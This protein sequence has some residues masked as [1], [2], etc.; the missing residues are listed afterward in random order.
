LTR[1]CRGCAHIAAMEFI[2][3][4][5]MMPDLAGVDSL[6]LSPDSK[7]LAVGRSDGVLEI[8]TTST[9]QRRIAFGGRQGRVPKCLAFAA[10][11]ECNVKKL[12]WAE[13]AKYQLIS[14]GL[15]GKLHL[16]DLQSLQPVVTETSGGGA[17]YDMCVLDTKP[18]TTLAL[19]CE[20]GA[21]HLMHVDEES[22]THRRKFHGG[23][24][25]ML[26]VCRHR[27]YVFGGNSTSLISRWS[28]D[29]RVSDS[30]VRLEKSRWGDE[31]LVWA[32][33]HVDE[34]S[35]VS[36]DSLGLLHIIDTV[37]C[38]V[39]QRLDQHQADVLTLAVGTGFMV[40]AGVDGRVSA[41]CVMPQTG[42]W[43][44]AESACRH[45]HDIRAIVM[46][47]EG[48]GISGAMD[49]GLVVHQVRRASA[50]GAVERFKLRHLRLKFSDSCAR[51]SRPFTLS[52]DARVGLFCNVFKA[53]LWY[54]KDVDQSPDAVPPSN[55]VN[56][57]VDAMRGILPSPLKLADVTLGKA[58]DMVLSSALSMDAQ[59]FAISD[60]AGTRLFS[61]ALKD[62]E[63]SRLPVKP[64]I[65][66]ARA[67]SLLFLSSSLLAI[68]DIDSGL[69]FCDAATGTVMA[70]HQQHKTPVDMLEA[71]PEFLAASDLRGEMHLYS[72]DQLAHECVVP[73]FKL[74]FPTAMTFGPK[75]A[76][77][78]AVSSAQEILVFDTE[79]HSVLGRCIIPEVPVH[80]KL[81]GVMVPANSPE[82]LLIW[83]SDVLVKTTMD[84]VQ[85]EGEKVVAESA[86]QNFSAAQH[87]WQIETRLVNILDVAHLAQCDAW[88]GYSLGHHDQGQSAKKKRKVSREP[89][90]DMCMILQAPAETLR[91]SLPSPFERKAY[92]R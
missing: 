78:I 50:Q 31:A 18:E 81:R 44:F 85:A 8:W 54:F 6:A 30:Y 46:S 15:D 67:L 28:L 68:G 60:Q 13:F 38:T 91:A 1:Q 66:A 34:T 86:A 12:R 29:T 7:W 52:N 90:G 79:Q 65:R 43:S 9:W 25:R 61:F 69:L 24:G 14:A 19:A 75:G 70:H 36:G 74:G 64:Q 80:Q 77:F 72:L 83:G 22:I 56:G 55:K 17:V 92:G 26:S 89:T 37:S 87:S 48:N 16:W 23:K 42:L 84:E 49:G 3:V 59:F 11:A 63:V 21:V 45:S 2:A 20:D 58:G 47:P 33:K 57:P 53:E 32:L 51:R 41:Y 76:R 10:L 62:M 88:S 71:S 27:N 82:K 39:L 35:I 4:H 40:A 5:C 73:R